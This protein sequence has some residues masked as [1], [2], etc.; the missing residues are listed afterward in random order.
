MKKARILVI[1]ACIFSDLSG[2]VSVLYVAE[3]MLTE[4]LEVDLVGDVLDGNVDG[5]RADPDFGTGSHGVVVRRSV[6]GDLVLRGAVA[7]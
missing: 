1:R 5:G 6:N 4:E 2:I 7:P 3:I